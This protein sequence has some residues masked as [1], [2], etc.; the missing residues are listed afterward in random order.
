LASSGVTSGRVRQATPPACQIQLTM[1]TPLS[2]STLA[3]RLPTSA[4]F[5]AA[6]CS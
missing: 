5:Q 2:S 1:I 4:V 3:R 6:P